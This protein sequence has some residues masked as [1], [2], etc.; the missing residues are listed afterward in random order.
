MEE[1][2]LIAKGG[3]VMKEEPPK[4]VTPPEEGKKK[5]QM[6]LNMGEEK[7]NKNKTKM[8]S[9]HPPKEKSLS[10]ADATLHSTSF[11]ASIFGNDTISILESVGIRTAK[12]LRD[13]A[14]T[15][16]SPLVQAVT[17]TRIQSEPGNNVVTVQS[18]V[19]VV[20]GWCQEL[21]KKLR[22]ISDSKSGKKSKKRKLEMISSTKHTS[23]LLTLK[24]GFSYPRFPCKYLRFRPQCRGTL[25]VP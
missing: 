19:S 24:G 23:E 2:D 8:N 11:L 6:E 25:T 4:E 17:S 12:D 13:A 10:K 16:D 9:D 15:V 5:K 20:N 3:K 22:D 18:S 1:N 21:D 7:N 14:K